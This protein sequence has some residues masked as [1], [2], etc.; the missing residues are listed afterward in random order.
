[1][2]YKNL[3]LRELTVFDLTNNKKVIEEDLGITLPKEI[4][5]EGVA[6]QKRILDF[7]NYAEIIKSNSLK[8]AINSQFKE[9]LSLFSF[10]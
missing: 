5:L 7:I 6:I 2:D 3:N 4:Y 8:E 9:E 1:M 10:E